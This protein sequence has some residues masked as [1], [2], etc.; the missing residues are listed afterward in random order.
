MKAED[1]IA[2]VASAIKAVVDLTP[3]VIKTVE[4][5]KPFAEVIW[6]NLKGRGAVTPADLDRITRQIAALSAQL[7]APLPPEQD[8]DV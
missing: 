5:A 2:T 3:V 7:Q 4:D 8:D 1:I 6:S